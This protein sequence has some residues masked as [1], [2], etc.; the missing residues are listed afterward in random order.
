MKEAVERGMRGA[1]GSVLGCGGR[2]EKCEGRSVGECM[3]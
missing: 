3:G 1:G 2:K